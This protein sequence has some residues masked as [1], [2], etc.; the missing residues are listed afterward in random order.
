M[1]TVLDAFVGIGLEGPYGVPVAITT[2]A[3]QSSSDMDYQP[4]RKQ[5]SGF[6]VGSRVARSARRVTP[7]ISAGG[8]IGFQ[9]LSKGY[10]K[11]LAAMLGSGTSTL[12]STGVYQH[13]FGLT[14]ALQSFTLQEGVPRLQADASAISDPLTFAGCVSTGFEMSM[15]QG[16]ILTTKMTVD[17]RSVDTSTALTSPTYPTAAASLFSFAGAS[18][19][20]G[21][22]TAPTATALASGATQLANIA[23]WSLSVDHNVDSKRYLM[24]GGGKKAKPVARDRKVSGKMTVE[25]SDTVFRDAFLADADMTLVV[26]FE[27]GSLTTGKETVQ[28]VIP[29]IRLDGELPKPTGDIVKMSCGYTG[30]DNLS[31]PPIQIIVRTSDATL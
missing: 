8:S 18:I 16:D 28:F 15:S 2:W 12:V 29:N 23:D 19:Y 14:D 1:S 13:V 3:E 26:N 21:T 6:R 20:S 31:A 11:L 24:G 25:Y 4:D 27:A 7:T 10:G 5:G 17:A 30:F 22:L 9:M